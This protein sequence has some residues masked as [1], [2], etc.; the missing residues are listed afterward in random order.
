MKI[1]LNGQQV[2]SGDARTVDELIQ[3]HRLPLATTLV[4]CNGT[5][6]RRRDWPAKTLHENDRLEIMQVAAGG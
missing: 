2:D 6:L 3:R 5:A 1:F 4:E